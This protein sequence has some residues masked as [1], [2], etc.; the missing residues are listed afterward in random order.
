MERHLS[1]IVAADVVDYSRLIAADGTA[2]LQALADI[3]ATLID[4]AL[5]RTGGQVFRLLGDSLLMAF[6][7]A[8]EA[9]EFAGALQTGLQQR[10]E[11]GTGATIHY[12][13]GID[14]SEVAQS[15]GEFHGEGINVASRLE[16]LA[17]AGGI[18]ISQA[19][20]ETLEAGIA[21][22]FEPLGL[23][24]L[25]NIAKPV[26]VWRWQVP[27]LATPTDIRAGTLPFNGQQFL[28]PKI[29]RLLVELHMRSARLALSDAVDAILTGPDAGRGLDF[30]ELY[31]RLGANLNRARAMLD[32]VKVQCVDDISRISNGK[33]QPVMSMGAFIAGVF[34]SADTSYAMRLVPQIKAILDTAEGAHQKRLS[35]MALFEG[36]MNEETVPRT[37][38]F[39]KCAFV[40]V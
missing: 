35:L 29:A 39:M 16:A 2:T 27:G 24:H 18:C 37:M 3:R 30:A 38:S 5:T 33:W 19:V 13:A 36:F 12:R 8:K 22:Q 6:A 40:E 15:G 17:P 21:T 7:S 11:T 34:D 4:P 14:L 25:H 1:A 26:A 32:K 23:R 20:Y 10:N 31:G 9:V 28:D